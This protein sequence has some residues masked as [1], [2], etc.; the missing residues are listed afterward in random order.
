MTL[1][2]SAGNSV[3]YYFSP[4]WVLFSLVTPVVLCFI[5]LYSVVSSKKPQI[6]NRLAKAGEW[7]AKDDDNGDNG[8]LLRDQSRAPESRVDGY[9]S[10][11]RAA[12]LETKL[13]MDH[14]T[15]LS[16]L[17]W[18]V[19]IWKSLDFLACLQGSLF[20]AAG[21]MSMHY[22]GMYAMEFR[23]YIQFHWPLVF[24]NFLLATVVVFVAFAVFTTAENAA[25]SIVASPICALAVW[26]VD[27]N[28]GRR[29]SFSRGFVS[30]CIFGSQFAHFPLLLR[31]VRCITLA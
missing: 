15:M 14:A 13:A 19:R 25:Q 1:I 24:A 16:V 20:G 31:L 3:D 6:S 5:G 9:E 7:T 26:Y 4:V 18:P 8:T 11:A 21:V 27:E 29:V 12:E 17:E 22:S 10:V 28:R 2:D 30:L 23:G